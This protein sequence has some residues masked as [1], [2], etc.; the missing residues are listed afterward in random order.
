M[1]LL[2][3]VKRPRLIVVVCC[4]A[5]CLLA[6]QFL[7]SSPTSFDSLRLITGDPMQP[8]LNDFVAL[9]EPAMQAWRTP[10]QR[11]ALGAFAASVAALFSRPPPPLLTPRRLYRIGER[12]AL[13]RLGAA[14][15]ADSDPLLQCSRGAELYLNMSFLNGY[16]VNNSIIDAYVPRSMVR[17]IVGGIGCFE[18]NTFVGPFLWM[19]R[20][21]QGYPFFGLSVGV[22]VD[23][24]LA[25]DASSSKLTY[26]Y[27]CNDSYSDTQNLGDLAKTL[28]LLL[29]VNTTD[30]VQVPKRRRG[31]P[32]RTKSVAITRLDGDVAFFPVQYYGLMIGQLFQEN[33]DYFARYYTAGL[34]ENN[35]TVVRAHSGWAKDV[36]VQA[37]LDEYIPAAVINAAIDVPYLAERSHFVAPLFKEGIPPC[38]AVFVHEFLLPRVRARLRRDKRFRY[39]D[40]AVRRDPAASDAEW[41]ATLPKKVAIMKDNNMTW[42]AYNYSGD[43]LPRIAAAGFTIVPNAV[44]F[45][46]RLLLVNNADVLLTT[47]GSLLTMLMR[48]WGGLERQRNPLRVIAF[49]HDGYFGERSWAFPFPCRWG[50][51]HDR[52]VVVSNETM[53]SAANVWTK[54]V[55][56]EQ[57]LSEQMHDD[58]LAFT[59][60]DCT[61]SGAATDFPSESMKRGPT[62]EK[63]FAIADHPERHLVPGYGRCLDKTYRG[64]AAYVPPRN[65]AAPAPTTANND[66]KLTEGSDADEPL[67]PRV[68]VLEHRV[69]EMISMVRGLKRERH[70]RASAPHDVD[71]T[72]LNAPPPTGSGESGDALARKLALLEGNIEKLRTELRA[73]YDAQREPKSDPTVAGNATK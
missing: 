73:E 54:T 32:A 21:L 12:A 16:L 31:R 19:T 24:G 4:A 47:F 35:V 64:G 69:E 43:A 34:L 67:L 55:G 10:P 33:F 18:V 58:H 7:R 13:A 20:S 36:G 45:P 6:S 71:G 29:E 68:G 61:I 17:H 28:K 42:R 2:V 1:N 14:W 40:E 70:I 30:S 44:P 22:D 15:F 50:K 39:G 27:H 3:N 56:L 51:Q 62:T 26:T 72:A 46:H 65:W 60:A 52:E 66:G 49:M 38:N 9:D 41:A 63:F 11:G 59:V 37:W 48:L 53:F 23:A 5:V 8:P 25:V 57:P